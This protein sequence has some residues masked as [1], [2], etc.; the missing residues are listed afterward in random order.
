[1]GKL[2]FPSTFLS[3]TSSFFASYLLKISHM[4]ICKIQTAKSFQ[5][6]HAYAIPLQLGLH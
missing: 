5:T 6:V 4:I 3:S 2:T 1:L